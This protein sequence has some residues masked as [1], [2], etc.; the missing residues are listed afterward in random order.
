MVSRPQMQTLAFGQKLRAVRDTIYSCPP[1][2]T[3]H[4][5]QLNFLLW[6][7]GEKWFDEQ[8]LKPFAERHVVLRW[9]DERNEVLERYRD[10]AAPPNQPVKAPLTGNMKALAVLADDI[11]QLEQALKSPRKIIERLCNM[12]EFQGA[13]YEILV[14]SLFA[15][16][17]F[18]IE[19][20]DD[21]AKKNPEF[22]ATKADE[23]VAVEAKSRHR[24][25]VLHERG[26]YVAEAEPTQA[27]I[28]GLFQEALEQDPGGLPFLVFID[29]NLPLT[30][31]TPPLERIWV[32]EAMKC[33]EERKSAKLPEPDSSLI[34]SNIGWHYHRDSGVPPPEFVTVKPEQPIFPLRSETWGLLERALDE[35]GVIVDEE[36]PP[37]PG[38]TTDIS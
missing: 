18:D 27:R 14:A 5:F 37:K 35:Y 2:G 38:F 9:R 10:P 13:R 26:E 20:I 1:E 25:G 24:P 33:F 30:P 7:L 17:G 3:F 11:Y 22:I 36:N 12:R 31:Q 8:M 16:C 23:R 4:D 19:F 29:V 34:L 15:R 32:K 6:T 21:R 28:R